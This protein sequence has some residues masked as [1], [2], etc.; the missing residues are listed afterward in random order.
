MRRF[1][2][3]VVQPLLELSLPQRIV[4]I[5]IAEGSHSAL[6][7][8]WCRQH[9][10]HLDMIDTAPRF[11]AEAFT[12]RFDGTAE[13]HIGKSLDVL[14]VLPGPD[15]ALIDGDH[16]WYTVY[17]E[18]QLLFRGQGGAAGPG[19]LCI[20]HDT[21]WPYGRRDLYYDPSN[22]PEQ[23]LHPWCRGPLLPHHSGI[24][25]V[26]INPQL[27]HARHEGGLR[28]GV[29][30]AI[31][32]FVAERPGC[33]RLV[34]LPIL[35]GLTL[36]VPVARLSPGEALEDFLTSLELSPHWKNLLRIEETER[37]YGTVA[38]QRLAPFPPTPGAPYAGPVSGRSFSPSLP[39]EILSRIQDGTM[40]YRYRDRALY[41]NPFD[42]ALYLRLLGQLRPRSV[43]E[44][45]TA[46]GGSALWFADMITV[47]GIDGRVLTIDRK[48]CA[49]L[50]D[51]RITVLAGDAADLGSV[52]PDSLL[53]TL[54]RPWLVVEDSA[55]TCEVSLAVLRFF[56]RYLQPGDYV[57]IED[58]V[59]RGLPGEQYL[60][61]LD[62]PSR[63]IESFLM[64]RAD[65]YEID[66]ESCDYYGFNVTYCPNG[67]LKRR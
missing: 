26:G 65:D 50:D 42:L 14:P 34:H 59:V 64:T 49:A 60:K 32:D 36:L 5:G 43:L 53:S 29:Q 23:Y 57:V 63:A 66:T 7:A 10:A 48:A 47:L 21:G 9:H 46:E 6:L 8:E 55:H 37:C 44:I 51:S 56:D 1:F 30:T 31:E 38:G 3:D 54:P 22:I 2:E 28:N 62:G 12:L 24:A 40:R 19:P 58:G 11:D 15:L 39:G 20:L 27:C 25:E 52:L 18:L 13:I 45:G 41:K 33:F 67:W 35:F 17:H 16:N 61:Y 4:E